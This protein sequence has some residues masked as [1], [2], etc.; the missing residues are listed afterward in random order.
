MQLLTSAVHHARARVH[1]TMI[2]T[3]ARSHLGKT[4][5]LGFQVLIV[6]AG[7]VEEFNG[8]RERNDDAEKREKEKRDKGWWKSRVDKSSDPFCCPFSTSAHADSSSFF[9]PNVPFRW[10]NGGTVLLSCPVAVLLSRVRNEIMQKDVA[11]GEQ[12]SYIG[13]L[14]TWCHAVS[15]ICGKRENTQE[16][17]RWISGRRGKFETMRCAT[18][19]DFQKEGTEVNDIVRITE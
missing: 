16:S 8:G 14:H 13:V 3:Y 18:S 9:S 12:G 5:F 2:G 1:Y 17:C 15:I 4:L 11:A 6:C 7:R 19:E 10:L